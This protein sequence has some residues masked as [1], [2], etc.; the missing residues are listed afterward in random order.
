MR[1]RRTRRCL[2]EPQ[3]RRLLLAL[4]TLLLLAVFFG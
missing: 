3:W 4:W 1:T 2:T